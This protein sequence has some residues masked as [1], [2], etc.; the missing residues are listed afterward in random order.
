MTKRARPSKAER[1]IRAVL[2]DSG[3]PYAIEKGAKHH[4]VIIAGRF[5][6]ILPMGSGVDDSGTRHQNMLANVRRAIREAKL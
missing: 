2:D 6:T 5:A 4:K 1:A 3:L